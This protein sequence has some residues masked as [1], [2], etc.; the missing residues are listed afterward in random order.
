MEP[1]YQCFGDGPGWSWRLLGSNHRALA[2]AAGTFASQAEAGA[3][4]LEAGRLAVEARIEMITEHGASWRWEM[5]VDGE[6]RVTSAAG[7]ARRLECVR[8]VA[9]F[10][11]CAP[12]AQVSAN[13]LQQR[14][15][16]GGPRYL[17]SRYPGSPHLPAESRR[18]PI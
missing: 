7:Y 12:V 1:R 14:P 6:V 13:P 10:R 8:A 17:A 9:R 4:A 11:L 18:E 15:G 5:T 16:A 3:D 2:R